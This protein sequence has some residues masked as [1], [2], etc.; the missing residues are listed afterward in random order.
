MKTMQGP[1]LFIAQ[2]VADAAPFN[3]L[4]GIASW[5]AGLG[6]AALQIPT[7]DKRVFD[8]GL[9]ATS[10]TYCEDLIGI[11]ADRELVVSELSTH[12]QG[13]LIAVHPAYDRLFDSFAPP[14]LRGDAKARAEWAKNQ[15][16]L[17]AEASA[18]L[19]PLCS[20]DFFRGAGLAILLPMAAKAQWPDR[21][22]LFRISRAMDAGPAE[23]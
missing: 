1:G 15:L 9:A 20:C 13:Q 11:L 10:K 18:N 17:A 19:G 5:A 21:R 2:F 4:D 6:F 12:L 14:A 23:V 22:S 16:F 3:T 7:W 8:L